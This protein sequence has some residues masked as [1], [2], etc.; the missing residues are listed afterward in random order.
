[1]PKTTRRTRRRAEKPSERVAPGGSGR[2]F[3]GPSHAATQDVECLLCPLCGL[4]SAK[5]N[6]RLQLGIALGPF[7][8]IA[9]MQHYGG[10]LPSPTGRMRDREGIMIW[11][12]P[13]PISEDEKDLLITKLRAALFPLV[14]KTSIPKPKKG[15]ND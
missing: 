7:A 15:S 6:P 11:D 2:T 12:P 5:S 4:T 3:I 13:H 9:R 1:M 14:V 8:P 10:S